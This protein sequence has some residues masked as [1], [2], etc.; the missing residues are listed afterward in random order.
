MTNKTSKWNY[1]IQYIYSELV[2]SKKKVN[3]IEFKIYILKVLRFRF[4]SANFSTII[5]F[6]IRNVIIFRDMYKLGI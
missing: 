6:I 1:L 3:N 5:K 2:I 4:G